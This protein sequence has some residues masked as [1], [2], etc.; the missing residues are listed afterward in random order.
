MSSATSQTQQTQQA[1]TTN[2][3]TR[4]GPRQ[5]RRGPAHANIV[6]SLVW[7][8]TNGNAFYLFQSPDRPFIAVMPATSMSRLS[9]MFPEDLSAFWTDIAIFSETKRVNSRQVVIH[10][11]DV[12]ISPFV[13][14]KIYIGLQL[15][16]R[17]GAWFDGSIFPREGFAATG[18]EEEPS[19]Q[20]I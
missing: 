2:S 5:Q 4:R 16:A 10:E 15:A 14:A 20:A 3:S 17:M 1:R 12:R 18:P 19:T 13:H 8:S 9:D 6:P 11:G 7:R